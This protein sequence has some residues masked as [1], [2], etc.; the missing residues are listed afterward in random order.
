MGGAGITKPIGSTIYDHFPADFL[1][2][3][4]LCGL[5]QKLLREPRVLGC[6]HTFCRACSEQVAATVTHDSGSASLK[7]PTSIRTVSREP[8]WSVSICVLKC[9]WLLY[10]A[11]QFTG[12]CTNLI[13]K[14]LF[15][16]HVAHVLCFPVYGFGR[17][18]VWSWSRVQRCCVGF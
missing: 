16:P 8:H 14:D 3:R 7:M 11:Y 13:S 4:F 5:C 10:K 18:L 12:W 15:E 1:P 2:D 9:V 17:S 6:L